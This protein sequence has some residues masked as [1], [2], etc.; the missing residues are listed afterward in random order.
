M[1]E[2]TVTSP[3]R[4]SISDGPPKVFGALTIA[5]KDEKVFRQYI[6]DE[7]NSVLVKFAEWSDLPE[8]IQ[9][10]LGNRQP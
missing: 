2:S 4:L 6:I 9:P 1:S 5:K 10:M 7:T 8:E 3:V